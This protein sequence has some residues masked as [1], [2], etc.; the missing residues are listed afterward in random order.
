MRNQKCVKSL[1]VSFGPKLVSRFYSTNEKTMS[2]LDWPEILGRKGP[3][4]PAH[5][6]ANQYI[7]EGKLITVGKV[8]KVLAFADI[9]ITQSKL[10][11]IL[12]EPRL[13]FSNLDSGTIRSDYF[14]QN[15]GT[16]RGKIQDQ[17]WS[18]LNAEVRVKAEIDQDLPKSSLPTNINNPKPYRKRYVIR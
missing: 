17:Y 4:L 12:S 18:W 1:L 10:D 3:L 13:E 9:K 8:N 14:L 16:V 5:R 2:D 6:L 15:I 7:K 11:K